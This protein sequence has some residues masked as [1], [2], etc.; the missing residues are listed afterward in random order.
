MATSKTGSFYLSEELNIS[1]TGTV[2]TVTMDLGAYVDVGD[3]QA[4][5]IE[6]VDFIVQAYDQVN[7]H[8]SNSLFGSVV[9]N[10]SVQFQLSDLN[11]NGEIISASTN[12]LIAS[13]CLNVDFTNFVT[14]SASD[15]F[16]DSYGKLDESRMVVNDMLY[17]T[18]ETIGAYAA[19]HEYRVT[20]IVKARIVKLGLKDWMSIAVTSTAES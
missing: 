5:A 3:Q 12:S 10:T 2:N 4:I 8:Y 13:G 17:L 19:N 15:D 11:P 6:K 18:G 14:T 7:D 1:A 9:A 20:A 16:P